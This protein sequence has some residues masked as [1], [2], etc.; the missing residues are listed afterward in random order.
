MSLLVM[1]LDVVCN[2]LLSYGNSY[3]LAVTVLIS[4]THEASSPVCCHQTQIATSHFSSS[5]SWRCGGCIIWWLQMNPGSFHYHVN[6]LH[7]GTVSVWERKSIGMLLLLFQFW[8]LWKS[9]T[10]AFMQ[11]TSSIL[12]NGL[13]GYWHISW[14][15]MHSIST[16]LTAS[17]LPFIDYSVK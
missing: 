7:Q 14:H 17:T 16:L 15:V 4:A 8:I 12:Q 13:M 6:M 1:K 10:N 9:S 3:Q 5:L 11:L 2:I